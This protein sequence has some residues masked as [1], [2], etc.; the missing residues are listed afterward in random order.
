MWVVYEAE[1]DNLVNV[2]LM[3]PPGAGKGTQ[4]ELL[5]KR[6]AL[7]HI[8]TGD[9]LRKA[10]LEKTKLGEAAKSYM[11]RGILVPDEVVIR[12]IRENLPQ[13]G[14]FLLD[15]FPRNLK[16]AKALDEMLA[17]EG[18]E[19][20]CV[21][22]LNVAEVELLKR[23]KE[24]ARFDDHPETVLKRLEVYRHETEPAVL[25]Y[26]EKGRLKWVDG[27]ASVKEVNDRIQREL[28]AAQP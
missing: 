15:G 11:D 25:Y 18:K 5:A 14:G 20:T 21:L 23:M 27:A 26:K 17:K 13:N 4:A 10:I 6:Y 12:L 22:N 16:Q 9:L 2:I 8:S 24:R 1:K 28:G 3:G 7:F 19:V